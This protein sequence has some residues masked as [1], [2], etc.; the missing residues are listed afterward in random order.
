MLQKVIVY[1]ILAYINAGVP[2][3]F[4]QMILNGYYGFSATPSHDHLTR[5]KSQ[6]YH[7]GL[8]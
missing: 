1:F 8:L 7:L 2:K 6:M 5:L 3:R 4:G